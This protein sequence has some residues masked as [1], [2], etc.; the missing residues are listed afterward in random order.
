M[1]IKRL[2]LTGFKSCKD[3]TVLDFPRGITGIVGPN[4]CGKS[5]IVD[6]LRWVLGEQSARH[7]RGQSMED[8]IFAGNERYA[9][10]GLAEVSVVL[11][12]EEG[13]KHSVEDAD[14]EAA[15]IIRVLKDVPEIE[16][17]RRLDRAGKSEY[18]ING[19]PCRLRDITE[20]FLGT[21]VGTKAYSM[22]EQG[23]VGQ[24]VSAKPEE[25]RLFVEEAAGTTLYRSRKLSAERKIERTQSNLARAND[26]VHELE[27]QARSLKRQV[28]GAVRYK[29]LKAEEEQF[30]RR[31]TAD[32]LRSVDLRVAEI[33]TNRTQA[34]EKEAKLRQDVEQRRESR[35]ELRGRML[36]ADRRTEEARQA[37]YEAKNR[38]N[39]VEQ[40]R[41]YL[42]ERSS[43]LEKSEADCRS[44]AVQL[45]ERMTA[46]AQELEGVN[47]QLESCGEELA[48]L[49]VSSTD[50][51]ERVGQA[52]SALSEIDR[53]L[54]EAKR[55]AAAA[56]AD[57]AGLS[58]QL[59][60]VNG[61]RLEIQEREGRLR[62]ESRSLVTLKE[63]IGEQI[64]VC[65]KR[66]RGLSQEIDNTTGGKE[67]ASQ[68]L[69]K[70]L[71]NRGE[72]E[73]EA[74]R[75][76]GEASK[77]SSR[78]D[79][80]K[81]LSESFAGYGDGVRAFMSNGGRNQVAAQAVVADVIEVEKGYER[82][83]AA[84]L[85][86]RVQHV[87]VPTTKDGAAGAAYLKESGTGRASFIPEKPRRI[88]FK[89]KA[90]ESRDQLTNLADHV[91]VDTAY[92]DVVGCLLDGVSVAPTLEA[93][94]A[95]WESSDG[96]ETFVT[97]DGDVVD[98]FGVV[99]GGSGRPADENILA[100][101]AELRGIEIKLVGAE[102]KVLEA[103]A[104][105]S[106]VDLE[107]KSVSEQ[108]GRLDHKL[109]ELTVAKVTAEGDLEL[110]RQNLLRT[111]DRDIAVNEELAELAAK[112]QQ[113]ADQ[114][115]EVEK[116]LS[117]GKT[118]AERT[119]KQT[120]EL[121]VRR[122]DS[123]ER[124]RK[125][126]EALES[127]RVREAELRQ[128]REAMAARVVDFKRR[129]EELGARKAQLERRAE[130]ESRE[131]VSCHERLSGP[132]LD[133]AVVTQAVEGAGAALDSAQQES[134]KLK[135]E[136]ADLQAEL[137][138][139]SSEL[140][141]ARDALSRLEL[142]ATECRIERESICEGLSER[143]GLSDAELLAASEEQNENAK[144]LG[145]E[146]ARIRA[147]IK[148]LGHV[149]V[150][151]VVELEEIEGRLV[152]LTSQRD[153]LERSID[154]LRGTIARLNR[155]SRNR[156]KSTFDEVNGIFQKVFPRL[157][158]GGRAWLA[159]SDENDLLETGVEV[160]VQPPGKKV[161]NLDLLSGG[162]KALTAVS[163]IFSLFM[164]KPSPFC[165]LDE[166]DAPLDDANVGRF[167]R[168]VAE[169]CDRSQFLLIT[170][171]KQTMGACDMLYGVTMREPGISRIVSVDLHRSS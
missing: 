84:V 45:T 136:S 151:A 88:S 37:F 33:D 133:P 42:T 55:K 115:R 150:G 166:V 112:D 165:V 70:V 64:Q 92:R 162:E 51:A 75:R 16:I 78:F 72:A 85:Q 144:E 140:E 24:I 158:E 169:M 118:L 109:H 81:E 97:L 12:N 155:L 35:E 101:K 100:Q 91:R 108:L 102:E 142:A 104:A 68:K 23:R 34:S 48:T 117:A 138:R 21:G 10:N 161:G 156:F 58:K 148:R 2:Q 60:V 47:H 59:D 121:T 73:R 110:Q 141:D 123:V 128:Q 93:A 86:D 44:E 87:I 116:K 71:S 160:Y 61:Q 1:R 131:L 15:E 98:G 135:E 74:E 28:R 111:E 80:L 63:K 129:L 41:R 4:G 18:L 139:L 26:I 77:L 6:A 25:L 134:T 149:N 113:L 132:E 39:S 67:S 96:S 62:E 130:N 36:I 30:D 83:V 146:L 13:L 8:V 152:E 14:E 7:L 53:E 3:K 143:L 106:A 49:G 5:N 38:L 32:R 65:Q 52:E 154:D 82:A 22:I 54:D 114:V 29:E 56:E 76:R 95:C 107:S 159:L 90:D 46:S 157:F 69:S 168:L 124:R 105:F 170:H 153:D 99:T 57:E 167:A 163:L 137:D 147:S 119:L 89:A 66:V 40:E 171:N 50:Q 20:L 79:S 127:I 145:D 103:Q 31:L 126:A 43:E 94:A 11:D 19:K 27:R 17:T 120:E 9:A 122:A 164:F 125:E